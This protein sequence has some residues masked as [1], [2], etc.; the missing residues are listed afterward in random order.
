MPVDEAVA[1]LHI[2]PFHSAGYLGGWKDEWAQ[3]NTNVEWLTESIYKMANQNLESHTQLEYFISK[4]LM[5]NFK[6][7]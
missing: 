1:T 2:E 5:E 4:R 7:N 6:V 3:Y